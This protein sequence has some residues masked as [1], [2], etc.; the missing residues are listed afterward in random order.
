MAYIYINNNNLA[1]SGH[2][3]IKYVV[4]VPT[5]MNCKMPKNHKSFANLNVNV[6]RCRY[7]QICGYPAT[8]TGT[9]VC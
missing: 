1:K 4:V 6:L 3:T 7:H 2:G 5:K 9:R 8:H